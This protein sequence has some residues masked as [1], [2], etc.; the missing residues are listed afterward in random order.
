LGETPQAQSFKVGEGIFGNIATINMMRKVARKRTGHPAVQWFTRNILLQY[1]VDSQNFVD[2]SKAVGDFIKS[3]V[4]YVRDPDGI[5]QL[6]D[7]LTMIE[8]IGRGVSQGDCDDMA[9]LIA[10]CLLSIGHQPKFRAVRYDSNSG[11]FNHIYVVDYDK[12]W[13]GPSVRIVLDAIM[14]RQQIG[15]EVKHLSGQDFSV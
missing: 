11:N 5:E 8:N 3:N 13:G 10:T 4:R 1:A 2:E 14:K 12:N 9:L 6:Q 7:P 15:F